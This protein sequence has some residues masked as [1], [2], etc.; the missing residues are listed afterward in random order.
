MVEKKQ[1][2]VKS[3]VDEQNIP[4]EAEKVDESMERK[5]TPLT[6][7]EALDSSEWDIQRTEIGVE[8][9]AIPAVG[10]INEQTQTDIYNSMQAGTNNATQQVEGNQE[11]KLEENTVQQD[12]I[13]K[14]KVKVL[15][16][17]NE[18]VIKAFDSAIV[19]EP[20]ADGTYKDQQGHEDDIAQS[21]DIQ[22]DITEYCC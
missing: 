4:T 12:E 7:E 10:T 13:E 5:H 21:T 22:S 11:L 15:A 6:S 18:D 8:K 2:A 16:S 17:L 9:D 19:D 1:N 14:E 20:F 3:D